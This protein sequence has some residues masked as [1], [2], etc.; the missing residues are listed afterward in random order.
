MLA[1]KWWFW[2]LV[3]V[4]LG[5]AAL[6][7]GRYRALVA[8]ARARALDRRLVEPEVGRHVDTRPGGFWSDVSWLS[9]LLGAWVA[10]SPWIWGYE[11][12]HGAV[13]TDAFTGGAVVA[14]TIAG[15]VFPALNALTI[16][17]GLWLV[18]APWVVGY[19]DEGGPVGLSDTL[20]GATIATLG[21]AALASAAKRIVPGETMPIG[22]VQRP[23]ERQPPE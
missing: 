14:L 5:A 8:R 21:I 1:D 10:A 19:G 15:I 18:L 17:A 11:D 6:A 16:V 4:L 20:A 7:S 12:V 9:I 13:A 23:I 3:G 2:L 22:R